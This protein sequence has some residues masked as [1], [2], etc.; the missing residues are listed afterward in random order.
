MWSAGAWLVVDV[1]GRQHADARMMMFVVVPAEEV[2]RV[3]ASIL[4]F[5][6]QRSGKSGLYFRVLKWASLKGLSLGDV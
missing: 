3:A 2:A 1:G 5:A 4:D 6:K